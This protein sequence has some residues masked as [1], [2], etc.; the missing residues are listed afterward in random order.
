MQPTAGGHGTVQEQYCVSFL[1]HRH[2]ELT[3][4]KDRELA[5]PL[6]CSPI[7]LLFLWSLPK[8]LVNLDELSDDLKN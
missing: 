1:F 2:L 5:A 8:S 6:P 3:I 4:V 7:A